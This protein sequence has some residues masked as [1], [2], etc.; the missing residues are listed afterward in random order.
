MSVNHAVMRERLFTA[1]DLF[2]AG[3]AL[4]RQQLRRADPSSTDVEIEQRLQAWLM[5]R[6]G[7]ECGDADGRSTA[8]PTR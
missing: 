1:F 2:E 5:E 6:P 7:A 8:W 3:V 4:K